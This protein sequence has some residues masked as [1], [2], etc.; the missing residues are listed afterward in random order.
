MKREIKFRAWN[1]E[2][3]KMVDLNKITPLAL[4]IEQDGVFVPFSEN[5][6]IMQF[7]GLKDKN[8]KEIYEGDILKVYQ[9]LATKEASHIIE[10]KFENHHI[11]D[12]HNWEI[13]GFR[14]Y[15][16]STY[17]HSVK[18]IGNIYENPKLLK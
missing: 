12:F 4:S 8:G 15:S 13:H 7:T 3:K 18:V 2:I 1:K 17:G 11:G 5:Y 14:D 6:E 10:V 16:K 9:K